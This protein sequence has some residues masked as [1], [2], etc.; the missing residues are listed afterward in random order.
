MGKNLILVNSITSASKGKKLLAENGI[1]ANVV[2]NTF[3][4]SSN[5]CGYA[6]SVRVDALTA[7]SILM[8]GGIKV[9]DIIED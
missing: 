1:S 4:D 2:R 8:Q 5:G 9:I 6:L 7:Q 3:H